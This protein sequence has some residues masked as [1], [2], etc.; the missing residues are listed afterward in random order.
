MS[1]ELTPE[2]LAELAAAHG[3]IEYLRVAN[4]RDIALRP[5]TLD[6]F[7]EFRAKTPES[8]ERLVRSLIVFPSRE[9]F[10]RILDSYPAVADSPDV[11]RAVERLTG[12]EPTSP[13]AV[14]VVPSD[15]MS[16]LK[17]TWDR[18]E[19]VVVADGRTIVMRPAKRGEY[20]R[21]RSEGLG[22][23]RKRDAQDTLVRAMTVFPARDELD[24]LLKAYPGVTDS[25]AVTRAC[26]RLTGLSLADAEGK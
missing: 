10:G 14:D 4:G 12:L 24:R 1:T 22:P 26:E 17:A 11:S 19:E 21:F 13:V 5:A 2:K 7:N 20:T 16:S 23:Q 9:E 6:E 8:Q 15:V 25:P 3:R 18:L